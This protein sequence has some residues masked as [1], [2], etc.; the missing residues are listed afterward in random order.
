MSA[1]LCLHPQH[2][3]KRQALRRG[4]CEGDK[5]GNNQYRTTSLNRKKK[6][7]FHLILTELKPWTSVRYNKHLSQL[8]LRAQADGGILGSKSPPKSLLLHKNMLHI[9]NILKFGVQ[10]IRE[11]R[12]MYTMLGKQE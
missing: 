8:G 6:A 4:D 9:P 11:L 1:A 3:E 12:T 7:T 10:P 5:N 2:L